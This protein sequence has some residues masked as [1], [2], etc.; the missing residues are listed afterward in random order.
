MKL[1]FKIPRHHV[2]E[3]NDSITKII[4]QTL[5]IFYNF[6]IPLYHAIQYNKNSVISRFEFKIIN[7]KYEILIKKFP[8]E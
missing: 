5:C 1:F 8:R 2:M 6:H 3:V 4:K 7:S